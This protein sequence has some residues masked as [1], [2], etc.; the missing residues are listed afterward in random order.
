MHALFVSKLNCIIFFHSC[1]CI[2]IVVYFPFPLG[3][4]FIISIIIFNQWS[5]IFTLCLV[6]LVFFFFIPDCFQYW[7]YFYFSTKNVK[8]VTYN[9][10]SQK[11]LHSSS[12]Q[13]SL[14]PGKSTPSSS[15]CFY[16]KNIK[17][18]VTNLSLLKK[19]LSQH[20]LL[21]A[22]LLAKL[23]K[24]LHQCSYSFTFLKHLF[25]LWQLFFKQPHY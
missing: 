1:Y 2:I 7:W 20:F 4:I 8:T 23:S 21:I 5:S 13:N 24:V 12:F 25:L 9:F 11:L 14:A 3:Q 19:A 22:S 17:I 15:N 18:V 16:L 10:S 6:V